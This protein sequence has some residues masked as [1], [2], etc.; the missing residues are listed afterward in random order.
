MHALR[1]ATA[2]AWNSYPVYVDIGNWAGQ[3][4]RR[5]PLPWGFARERNVPKR[6]HHIVLPGDEPQLADLRRRT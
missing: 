6:H 5:E 1:R 2:A 4:R 3:L